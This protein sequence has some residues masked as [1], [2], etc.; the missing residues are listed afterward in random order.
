[1]KK[2]S[3]GLWVFGKVPDRYLPT[4]YQPDIAIAEKLAW[5]AQTPG[6]S[7]V[8]MPYGG[9]VMHSGNVEQLR[10]MA[11][12]EG[13][14]IS[15]LA[16]NVTGN[17][18][19]SLGSLT[20]PDAAVRRDTIALIGEA[21]Q[22][23]KTIGTDKVNL[24]M[25][26]DGFDYPFEVDYHRMWSLLIEGLAECATCCPQTKLCI[27][28]KRMEPR[29]RCLP[30]SASQSLLMV[31][32]V[33]APNIGVTLDFGHAILG[34]E[35][36][37]QS[38]VMLNDYSK[39][40]HLHINDNYADWDWD[41]AAGVDHWW[42]LVEFCYWLDRIG[43]DDWLVVDIFPYRQDPGKLNAMS[44][45]ACRKAFVLAQSLDKAALE[46]GFSKHSAVEVYDLFFK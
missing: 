28:Y 3:T 20:N 45:N 7:G 1:M 19:W 15:S 34:G 12:N 43:Y 13:L 33:G 11:A 39:L 21:M 37:S 27:E 36:A 5:I 10:H 26:Q 22:V 46:E 30:N 2:F 18:K 6:V 42:Q 38:A 14:V 17:R 44:V 23:A 24:W 16:V 9:P 4:G 8:E 31:Q 35:N 25:G 32:K 41:M 40:Y 29:M